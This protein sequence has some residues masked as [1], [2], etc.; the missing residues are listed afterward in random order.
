MCQVTTPGK[1]PLGTAEGAKPLTSYAADDDEIFDEE[2]K[3]LAVDDDGE[4]D[5]C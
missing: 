4:E 1:S 3:R 2:E 5:A